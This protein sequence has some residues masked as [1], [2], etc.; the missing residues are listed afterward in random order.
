MKEVEIKLWELTKEEACK[1]EEQQVL[2]YNPIVGFFSLDFNTTKSFIG[3]NKH[4]FKEL[5]YFCFFEPRF[6]CDIASKNKL[7]N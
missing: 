4:A 1:I 6:T 5:K 2:V 7:V 3:K